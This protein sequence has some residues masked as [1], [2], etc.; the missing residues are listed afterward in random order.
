MPAKKTN[1]SKIDQDIKIAIYPGTFDPIT[2][3]HV[4]L[5]NRS[6]DIFDGLIVAVAKN[7]GKTPMF[8]HSE[9]YNLAKES[10]KKY[11][12]VEVIKFDGLLADLAKVKG[13]CAI[14]RGLRA[15]SDFEYEFQMALMNRR[16]AHDVETVFLMPSLS[17]VYLSSTIVKD[18]AINNGAIEGLVPTPVAEAMKKKLKVLNRKK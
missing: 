9:R 11:R 1:N 15:V 3:G 17:W 2:N 10:L 5:V 7:A 8:N 16:L 13:A 18:V 14:I 12:K 4:S 6:I